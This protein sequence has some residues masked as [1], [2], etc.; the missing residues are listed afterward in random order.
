MPSR[1]CEKYGA[2]KSIQTE[3]TGKETKMRNR[4]DDL[5]WELWRAVTYENETAAKQITE[6][7]QEEEQRIQERK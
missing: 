2:R 1:I 5:K 7:I 6:L 3:K 4:L